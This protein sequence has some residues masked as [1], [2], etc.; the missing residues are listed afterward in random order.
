MDISA[1]TAPPTAATSSSTSNAN[2]TTNSFYKLLAA[3]I[4]YQDPLS[5]SDSGGSSGSSNTGSYITDLAILSATSAIQDMTKVENYTMASAMAG[6]TVAYTSTSTSATGMVSSTTKTGSV[7]SV[8]FTGSVPRCYIASTTDGK[9]TGEW[10]DYTAI[11][12]VYADDVTTSQDASS[13]TTV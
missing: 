5:S 2:L 13:A 8:D 6:K 3:Q 11:T 12:N 10:V 7:E 4:Q 9:T 1:I